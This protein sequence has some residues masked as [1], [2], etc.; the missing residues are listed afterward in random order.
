MGGFFGVASKT[1]CT[2]DLFFGVDYHSHLG[3]R[4]GG[5]AVYGPGGFNRS[6]HNIENSPFRTKFERDVDELQGNMGIACISDM[7]PQPL[8]IQSHL[9]S[10]AIT[11]VGKIANQEDLIREAYEKGHIH[12]L[13][14][15][16]GKINATELVAAIINQAESIVDGLLLA[17]EKII[18]SMTILLLTPEAFTFPVTE[19]D[20]PQPSSAEKKGLSVSLSKVLLTLILALLITV[21]LAR[22][23]LS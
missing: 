11:T 20:V 13:E 15:S 5:M 8:L 14:M 22:A 16:G 1:N 23:R 18:G 4:R 12:F 21:N 17:Q 3:T 2:M 6:I 9:G 7:E 10:Y 19:K